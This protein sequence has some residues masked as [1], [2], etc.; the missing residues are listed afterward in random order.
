MQYQ[1]FPLINCIQKI[2]L[3]ETKAVSSV[4]SCDKLLFYL[5]TCC[6][7][8]FSIKFVTLLLLDNAIVLLQRLYIVG[9][10]N[11]ETRFRVLKIDRTEPRELNIVD[12]KVLLALV[13]VFVLYFVL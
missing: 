1:Q 5:L 9:S 3:Y 11:T 8:Q 2:V 7:H 4:I 10:N 6:E 12:D 13:V